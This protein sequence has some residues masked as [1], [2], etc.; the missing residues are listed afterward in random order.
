MRFDRRLLGWGL[1]FI[2]LGS[3]PLAVQA[4]A[5]GADVV[6]QWPILWPLL[7][8]GWGIGLVLRG[9]PVRWIGGAVTAITL[10]AM[11]GG[12]IATGFNGMPVLTGC[13]GSGA[14]TA[15]QTQHGTLAGTARVG[16]EFGC[17]DL[18]VAMT[19]GSDWQLSGSDPSGHGPAS[20]TNQSGLVAL[21]SASTDKD[22]FNFGHGRSTWNVTLPRTPSLD[23]GLTL[24][25]G[26]GKVDLGGA[27]LASLD[28]TVNAGSIDLD[29]LHATALPLDSVN[30]TINAGS[31]TMR[32]PAFNGTANLSLNAG[33][34]DVCVPAGTALQIE[35]SGALAS[36]DFDSLG[37]VRL[38]QNS[39]TT[40]QFSSSLDH[41]EL[42]V[43][44][45]AGSFGLKIGGSC[46]A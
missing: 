17:G 1:F 20:I 2:V 32:L 27:T 5:V 31:A 45:N 9:T 14:A 36:N 38:D 40:Q 10:G 25:A 19:D 21:R 33:S 13:G 22:V 15:F 24:D 46:G 43:S 4:G 30:A 26:S 8:I 42:H 41:I 39:W 29:A 37:L 16:I 18:S 6:E 28:V 11:G 23:L 35:W 34:L 44:A 3:V 12:L 7:L